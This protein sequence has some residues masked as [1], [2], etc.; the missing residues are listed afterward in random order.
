MSLLEDM[1]KLKKFV[2]LCQTAHTVNEMSYIQLED[3]AMKQLYLLIS[4]V[5]FVGYISSD[6][7]EVFSFLH[8]FRSCGE[9]KFVKRSAL[10]ETK[11]I[12][13]GFNQI[14]SYSY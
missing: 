12:W 8:F 1:L 4:L 14:I 5:F 9:V 13:F 3:K 7:E 2:F 10:G 6:E 11:D